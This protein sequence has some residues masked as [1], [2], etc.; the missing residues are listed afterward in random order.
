[1]EGRSVNIKTSDID[2]CMYSKRSAARRHNSDPQRRHAEIFS[3]SRNRPP[4]RPAKIGCAKPS[5]ARHEVKQRGGVAYNEPLPP[6]GCGSRRECESLILEGRVEV[7]GQVVTL[8][9]NQSGPRTSTN[10]T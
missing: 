8:V 6:L 3:T 9:G 1:M 2:K 7:D 4:R 10:L 5:Q